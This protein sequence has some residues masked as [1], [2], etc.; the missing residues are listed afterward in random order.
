MLPITDKLID[1]KAYVRDD[2]D[3]GLLDER[4]VEVIALHR[5][6]R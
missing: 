1:K 2:L 4:N 3:Q 5:R 6:G